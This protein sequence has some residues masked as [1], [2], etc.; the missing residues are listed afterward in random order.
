MMR[1]GSVGLAL[2]LLAACSSDQEPSDAPGTA[3][4]GSS[5]SGGSA[6]SA[7][8]SAAGAGSDSSAGAEGGAGNVAGDAASPR[9]PALPS[10]CPAITDGE[11][12]VLGQQV[13][14]WTGP[15][16]KKGPLVFYWH[17]TGSDP[18][19][20]LALFDAGVAEVRAN[21]G[22]V[23]S[24]NKTTGEGRNTGNGVWHVG[25]FEMSD[26]IFACAVDQGLVDARRVYTAGCSAGG[27]QAS[28]MVY[29]RSSY[30]A[31]AM[32]NSGGIIGDWE[33]EDATHVPAL[34]T[35]HG[36]SQDFVIISFG[37]ASARLDEDIAGKG[38]FVVNCNHG[39]D[40]C[41]SPVN[42]RAA[43][44]QFLQAHPFG[45]EPEPYDDGLPASFPEVCA[46]VQ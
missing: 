22:V 4:A 27:L 37:Q 15:V 43:Q 24:F 44:W 7:A 5:A 34:I 36:G 18:E 17:G 41:A 23:A 46:V 39:G 45:I 1:S 13:R 9:V 12:S 40:H 3:G 20:A 6:A 8:S 42:V 35:A 38:G 29:S 32:P 33:L 16:G 14:I 31:A 19:E 30:L 28:A 2:A 11:I 10:S 25:D 21:G 26:I